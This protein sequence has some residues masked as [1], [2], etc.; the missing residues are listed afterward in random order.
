MA[1]AG[2]GV[3]LSE[4]GHEK[5]LDAYHWRCIDDLEQLRMHRY[6]KMSLLAAFGLALIND[7]GLVVDMLPSKF[8][9]IAAPL[10]SQR[11]AAPWCRSHASPRTGQCAFLTMSCNQWF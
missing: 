8:D 7:Q 1:E 2:C 4:V 10:A 11:Q 5:R 9:D 6:L 3:R